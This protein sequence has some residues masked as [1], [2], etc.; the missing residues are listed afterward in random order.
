MKPEDRLATQMDAL[1]SER[2]PAEPLDEDEAELLATAR[3]VKWLRKPA[4]P[5]LDFVRRMAEGAPRP[6]A[7]SGSGG[8]GA[9]S[10]SRL[11]RW[12]AIPTAA[13]VAAAVIIGSTFLPV[14]GRLSVVQ[15]MEQTVA[16]IDSYHAVVEHRFQ[17]PDPTKV[18]IQT[19]EIWYQGDQYAWNNGMREETISNGEREWRVNHD[20]KYVQYGFP[21]TPK[22]L[23]F[24]PENLLK[25]VLNQPYTIEGAEQIAGRQAS[26]VRFEVP[27]LK[28]YHMW[29]DNET[30]LPLQIEM[31]HWGGTV[32]TETYKTFQLNLTIDPAHFTYQAPDGYTVSDEGRRVASIAEAAAA[33]GF[34]PAV[35]GEAP[36]LIVVQGDQVRMGFGDVEIDEGPQH[37]TSAHTGPFALDQRT[38]YGWTGAV[39]VRAVAGQHFWWHQNGVELEIHG[40]DR[41][42][43]VARQIAPDLSVPYEPYSNPYLVSL[44]DNPVKVDMDAALAAEIEHAENLSTH[45]DR[46][47]PVPVAM[48]FV[49]GM[50]AVSESAF[51]EAG[52]NGAEAI[53]AISEGPVSKVYLRRVARQDERGL[54]WVIGYDKR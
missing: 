37:Q 26:R 38:D 34:Q 29:I 20:Q 23:P 53:V 30:K 47:L 1:R 51:H 11:R 6:A 42:L 18:D 4:D 41:A 3:A 2:R 33:V 19:E 28:A 21:L 45:G 17:G 25:S 12:L 32:S 46:T 7:G 50:A 48:R 52:N 13:A 54:W 14:R 39:P 24:Q 35:P 9:R 27:N 44:I 49:G 8:S 16:K 10:R 31:Q 5:S 15:A 36:R 43:D 40:S 22:L